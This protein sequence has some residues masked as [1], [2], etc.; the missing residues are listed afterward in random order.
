VVSDGTKDAIRVKFDSINE[1]VTLDSSKLVNMYGTWL[2]HRSKGSLSSYQV[3][4]S[5]RWNDFDSNI[6][7]DLFDTL[8]F[9]LRLSST[10]DIMVFRDSNRLLAGEFLQSSFAQALI[11]SEV[12]VPVVSASA[13]YRMIS[14]DPI[15]VDNVLVEWVLGI[16]CMKISCDGDHEIKCKTNLS[17]VFPIMLGPTSVSDKDG[18]TGAMSVSDLFTCM[19]SDGKTTLLQSLPEI[20]PGATIAVVRSLLAENSLDSDHPLIAPILSLTVREIVLKLTSSLG[21]QGWTVPVSSIAPKAAGEVVGILRTI[22]SSSTRGEC[23]INY[24]SLI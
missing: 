3:F 1:V 12:M 13:L 8:S 19:G 20:V 10:E 16:V 15:T 23:P 21:F 5:Y 7:T 9:K 24:I 6:V 18:A 17:K 11:H 14:H 2:R 4:L 22:R